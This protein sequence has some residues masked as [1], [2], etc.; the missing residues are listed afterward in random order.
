[1]NKIRGDATK[2]L[3]FFRN[4]AAIIKKTQRNVSQKEDKAAVVCACRT[5]A[6]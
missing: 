6:N 1:M 5:G 2:G 3:P 4:F